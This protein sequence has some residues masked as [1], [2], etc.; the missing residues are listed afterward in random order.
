M[1]QNLRYLVTVDSTTGVPVKVE[2]VGE[3]G[4]LSE[5]DLATFSRF[6]GTG[7]AGAGT[8]APQV[9]VNI[10]TGGAPWAQ[11]GAVAKQGGA[12]AAVNP[13]QILGWDPAPAS[14][15]PGEKPPPGQKPPGQRG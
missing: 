4:D 11:R 13:M 6:W 8:S 9:V 7:D 12:A 10:F 5:M 2:Q 1:S 14:P 3:A 15:P